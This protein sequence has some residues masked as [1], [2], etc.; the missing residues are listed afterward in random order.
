MSNSSLEFFK[1]LIERD[2]K[3][4]EM[5]L[6]ETTTS[7]IYPS[8]TTSTLRIK[9]YS[10]IKFVNDVLTVVLNDG[11]I[12]SKH[13][14]NVDDFQKVR[15][16]K[17]ELEVF[18]ICTIQEAYDDKRKKDLEI[19]RMVVLAEG[20]KKLAIHANY[21]I[22]DD[23][24]VYIKG[25]N[26]SLPPLLIEEFLLV[27][28]KHNPLTE[29]N[30]NDNFMA[31]YN[32]WMWC[33]LNPR[34]EVADKLFNFLKKNSFRITKQGFFTALRN[35]VTIHGG[36]ELVQFISETYNKVKAVWKKSPNDYTIFLKDGEYVL[37]KNEDIINK[38]TENICP[39]CGGE[40]DWYDEYENEDRDCERCEG[41]G[42]IDAYDEESY[43]DHGEKIGNLIDLYLDLPNREENRFTDAH[44]G[45][46]DIRV[47]KVVQMDP[48]K[49]R[50]NTDDCGAEGLK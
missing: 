44:T 33:C 49:C 13:P 6:K 14:A 20:V 17:S 41:T 31:L 27:I 8:N 36:T 34:A 15:N 29:L 21:F 40:G 12:I 42:E 37:V 7:V 4:A 10:N 11:N 48:A 38:R 22:I 18:D 35:V 19:E 1:S 26:R 2:T 23:N 9:P 45:T 5:L 16:A 39:D 47:G 24:S 32:F 25:I 30:A 28:S 43:V 46:F 50:W 3:V